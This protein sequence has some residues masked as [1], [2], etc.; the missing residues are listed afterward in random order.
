MIFFSAL[1]SELIAKSHRLHHVKHTVEQESWAAMHAVSWTETA[2]H[3]RITDLHPSAHSRRHYE[4]II[5]RVHREYTDTR[6][7]SE[8]R[9]SRS[10]CLHS[11]SATSGTIQKRGTKSLHTTI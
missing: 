3:F 10:Y 4:M 6:C 7:W 5:F 9:E 11:M 1:F 2:V 8:S